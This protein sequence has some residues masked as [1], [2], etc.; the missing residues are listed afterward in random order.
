[1][2]APEVPGNHVFSLDCVPV[3]AY[4]VKTVKLTFAK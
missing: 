2:L 3:K 1:M 4:E